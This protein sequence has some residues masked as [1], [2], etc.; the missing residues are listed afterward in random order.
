MADS[1]KS[2]SRRPRRP[3]GR[4]HEEYVSHVIRVRG[5]EFYFSRHA[6]DPR[7]KWETGLFS[8]IGNLT[9]LGDLVRPEK[10]KFRTGKLTFNGGGDVKVKQPEH[11]LT[12]I[13][14]ATSQGDEIEGYVWVSEER[15]RLLLT[16]AQSGQ[17]Q[18]AHFS[19][20]KLRYGAAIVNS[21][22]IGTHFDEDEW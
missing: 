22:S 4:K 1:S 13:G 15:L 11:R 21:V 9:L 19:G 14:S 10:S 3:S 7:S 20:P 6:T 8:D 18:F 5:W 17:L 16:A 12:A 2:R